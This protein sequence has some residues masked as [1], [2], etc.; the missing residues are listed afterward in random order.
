MTK[1]R[2][3][4]FALVACQWAAPCRCRR[5]QRL[6]RKIQ[7]GPDV[8]Q[9]RRAGGLSPVGERLPKTRWW[10]LSERVGKYGG[11]WRSGMITIADPGGS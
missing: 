11:T 7:G 3:F 4:V 2:V 9:A 8:N 6:Q 5:P 1:K 10:S